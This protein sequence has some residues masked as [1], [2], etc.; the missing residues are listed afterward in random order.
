MEEL[1]AKEMKNLIKK[2]ESLKNKAMRP[3]DG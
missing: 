2:S 1:A 3:V